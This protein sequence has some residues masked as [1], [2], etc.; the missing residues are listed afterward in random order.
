MH[1][2]TPCLWYDG[3]AE[4]AANFYVSLFPD[5]R[6]DNVAR[7]PTDT[8]SGKEGTV[9]V[10]EC[11]VWNGPKR[12]HDAIDQLLGYLTRRDAASAL[13]AFLRGGVPEA[14]ARADAV[15]RR[16]PAFVRAGGSDGE[17]RSD[18]VLRRGDGSEVPFTFLPVG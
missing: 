8:P 11:K 9:L 6:V 18:Y 7:S 13:V 17:G 16:H 1:N 3:D 5:S 15:I 12:L 4:E 10:V 14:L 2:I